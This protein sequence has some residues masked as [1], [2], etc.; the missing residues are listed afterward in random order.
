MMKNFGCRRRSRHEQVLA[1]SLLYS[2]IM[3]CRRVNS[4]VALSFHRYQHPTTKDHK[5]IH[6]K[7]SS[8]LLCLYYN[9]NKAFFLSL[10]IFSDIFLNVLRSRILW[11]VQ[12]IIMKRQNKLIYYVNKSVFI[13]ALCWGIISGK[14]D[15]KISKI[16]I[17]EM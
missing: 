8:L 10:H 5:I 3:W 17:F 15:S 16:I 2:L 1:L 14:H 12:K 7:L 11:L 4:T 6:K 9:L 13:N